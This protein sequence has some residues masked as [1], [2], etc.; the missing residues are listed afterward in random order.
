MATNMKSLNGY[1][2]DAAMLG[3]RAPEYYVQ[4]KNLLDNS[5]FRNPVAQAGVAGMHGNARYAL[6]RWL[7]L[8][9]YGTFS[10]DSAGL[11]MAYETNHCYIAQRLDLSAYVGKPLTL[12][13]KFQD[14]L[15]VTHCDAFAASGSMIHDISVYGVSIDLYDSTAQVVVVDANSPQIVEWMALYEG[16]YTADTLPPYVPKGYAAELAECQRYFVKGTGIVA[17]P[18]TLDGPVQAYICNVI[19]P[20]PMR[21]SHPTV[22]ISN[23]QNWVEQ[24]AADLGAAVNINDSNGFNSINLS[25]TYY[26]AL[27]QFDYYASA[28]L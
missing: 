11:H 12:A 17:R 24:K 14:K 16:V 13:V 10:Q 7:N 8:Y 27:I 1:G 21:M 4:P 6:D 18:Y 23:I 20:T 3:G 5:D 19:Y 9:G 22:V 2:F 28:D 25:Q 15:V 26:N